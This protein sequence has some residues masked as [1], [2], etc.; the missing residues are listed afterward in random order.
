M[1]TFSQR[2]SWD[3]T[4][5]ALAECLR[6]K[7]ATGERILDLTESNP[8]HCNVTPALPHVASL[9]KNPHAS[10]YNPDPRG[11]LEAR[12]AVARWYAQRGVSVSPESVLLTTGTSEAYWFLMTL[13]CDGGDE[14]LVPRPTYPLVEL[15]AQAHDVRLKPYELQYDGEW[16]MDTSSLESQLSARTRGVIVVHPNNP[17]GSYVKDTERAWLSQCLG[18]GD[19][20]LIA[21]EVFWNHQHGHVQPTNAS[22]VQEQEVLTFVLN[23]LSKVMGLPQLKLSWIVVAGPAALRDEALE[24]LEMLTDLTLSVS[25]P[26]QGALASLLE[27][28]DEFALPVHERITGNLALVKAVCE[29]G[30]GIDVLPV[31]GGWSAVL[32]VPQIVSD[33]EWALLLL[34]EHGVL[35]HPGSHFDFVGGAYLVISLLPES[36]LLH[37]GINRLRECVSARVRI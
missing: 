15:L 32:R 33:E 20:A 9:L 13:L 26:I 27:H 3:R 29:P 19:L 12:Q 4:P 6:K 18:R 17:T 10:A 25:M 34:E 8:T 31:E 24:R 22:F 21:D 7:H 28:S 37:D 11:I 16:R 23:G 30:S 1:I 2:T 36:R 35:V 5:T 14:I